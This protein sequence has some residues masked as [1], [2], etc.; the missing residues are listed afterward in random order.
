M[1][2]KRRGRLEWADDALRVREDVQEEVGLL[3]PTLELFIFDE[4][5]ESPGK[6]TAKFHPS[7]NDRV[8]KES[9]VTSAAP[10]N[11]RLEM[12]DDEW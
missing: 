11:P 5:S 3:M 1:G 10:F 8:S 7:R 4:S 6:D 12:C 2:E 9:F